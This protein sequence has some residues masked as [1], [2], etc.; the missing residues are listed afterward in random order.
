M[1]VDLSSDDDEDVIDLDKLLVSQNRNN[2]NE[3]KS[4][5][6][7]NDKFLVLRESRK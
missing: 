4:N 2:V 1:H 7:D 3:E 6:V 5:R